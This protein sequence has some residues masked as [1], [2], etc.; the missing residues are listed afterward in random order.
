MFVKTPSLTL[1]QKIKSL[2]FSVLRINLTIHKDNEVGWDSTKNT[3]DHIPIYLNYSQTNLSKIRQL[4]N[5]LTAFIKKTQ[6]VE[7]NNN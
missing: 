1:W 2:F 5:A 3:S 7:I 6:A 4:W